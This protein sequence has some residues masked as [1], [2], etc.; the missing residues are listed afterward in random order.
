MYIHIY[1]YKG[2]KRR[3]KNQYDIQHS[4]QKKNTNIQEKLPANM[5]SLQTCSSKIYRELREKYERKKNKR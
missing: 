1:V 5:T 3:K 2:K 4:G